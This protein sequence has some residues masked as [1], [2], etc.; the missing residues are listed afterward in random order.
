VRKKQLTEEQ[1]DTLEMAAVA[2]RDA[3]RIAIAKVQKQI[4]DNMAATTA[5]LNGL[6]KLIRARVKK[7]NKFPKGVA[8]VETVLSEVVKILSA[9]AEWAD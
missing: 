6:S 8:K 4:V 3:E 7:M 1:R 9:V 5:E 2:M